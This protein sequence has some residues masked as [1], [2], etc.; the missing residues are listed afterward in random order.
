MAVGHI[1]FLHIAECPDESGRIRDS[2]DPVFNTITGRK[3]VKRIA[4]GN[5]VHQPADRAGIAEGEHHRLGMGLLGEDVACSV[6]FFVGAR[7]LVLNDEV[8]VVILHRYAGKKTRLRTVMPFQLI[9]VEARCI[10]LHKQ[11]PLFEGIQ[12]IGTFTVGFVGVQIKAFRQIDLRADNMKETVG[13]AVGH[14]TRFV[15]VDYIVRY[16]GYP[17]YLLRLWPPCS[18]WMDVYHKIRSSP[19]G[20]LVVWQALPNF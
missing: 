20:F 17:V 4:P 5:A 11:A 2:P 3:M 8:I 18:E 19:A 7:K 14:L 9:D 13:V 1:Q 16:T 10:L 12:I 6:V 15:C